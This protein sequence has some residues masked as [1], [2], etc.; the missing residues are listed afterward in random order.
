MSPPL[1]WEEFH[2]AA[3]Y[4]ML[5][6]WSVCSCHANESELTSSLFLFFYVFVLEPDD[7]LTVAQSLKKE[8]DN[9]DTA[10]LRFQVDGK[11]VHVHKVLLKIR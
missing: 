11:Y 3:V 8:F 7:H 10:D 1:L 5:L 2:E 9:P 6:L 4:E